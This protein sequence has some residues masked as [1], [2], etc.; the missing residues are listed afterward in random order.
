MNWKAHVACNFNNLFEN[1]R[2]SR[3][4]A[5]THIVNVAI[6]WKLCQMESLLLQTTNRK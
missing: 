3:S 4:Q 1:E 5:V 2:L 6:S